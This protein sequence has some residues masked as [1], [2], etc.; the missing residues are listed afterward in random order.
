MTSVP[1]KYTIWGRVSCIGQFGNLGK[2]KLGKKLGHYDQLGPCI[3][4]LSVSPIVGV[5]RF[6]RNVTDSPKFKSS[7]VHTTAAD[8]VT[9][10]AQTCSVSV[11]HKVTSF[12]G[13]FRDATTF[14]VVP[15]FR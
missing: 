14:N 1:K 6:F 12:K 8:I 9:L 2:T 3:D 13:N 15:A 5:K 4:H 7:G 10:N 11:G